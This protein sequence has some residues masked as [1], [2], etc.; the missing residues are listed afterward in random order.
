MLKLLTT[1]DS[2]FM[3]Y[4]HKTPQQVLYFILR[5]LIDEFYF[6]ELPCGRKEMIHEP[7][8]EWT[9]AGKHYNLVK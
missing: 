3:S 6:Y 5:Y 1:L 8:D 9:D 4:L 2:N 7:Y